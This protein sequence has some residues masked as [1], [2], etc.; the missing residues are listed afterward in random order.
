MNW[1]PEH[2]LQ[3]QDVPFVGEVGILIGEAT[4]N[5]SYLLHPTRPGH[6]T[7]MLGWHLDRRCYKKCILIPTS[8]NHFVSAVN[9]H[10]GHKGHTITK[11]AFGTYVYFK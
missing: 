11:N 1:S 3:D 2:L 6:T 4:I 9:K 7:C 5:A 8:G 10:Q